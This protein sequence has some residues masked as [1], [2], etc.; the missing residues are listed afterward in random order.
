MEWY[1]HGRLTLV[2]PFN[3]LGPS[4]TVRQIQN[5]RYFPDVIFKCIFLNENVW[6][7]LDISLKFVL[8]VQ[9]TI[10]QHWFR[11][12]LGIWQATSHSLN[13]LWLVYWRLYASIGLSELRLLTLGTEL[14]RCSIVRIIVADALDPCV[15]R[16]AATMIL[17]MFLSH[18]RKDFNYPW[19]VNV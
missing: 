18:M 6:I 17:T 15:A 7:L 16:T 3:P 5:G 8:G 12:G 13:Q 9:L 10:F 11:S 2:I 1:V 4:D 19:H 14:S